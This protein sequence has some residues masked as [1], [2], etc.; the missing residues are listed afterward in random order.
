MQDEV[1]DKVRH[2]RE[3]IQLRRLTTVI[4]VIYA[5]VIWRIF[6]LLPAPTAEQLTWE[7][8]GPFLVANIF[9][10]LIVF[11]GLVV[12]IIYWL[13]HNLL[14]G[15]LQSTDTRHSILSILQIF[16]LLAFLLSLREGIELGPSTGTRALESVTAA[17]VGIAGG[18]GWAYAIKNHRLLL[19]EVTEQYALQLRDRILAEPITAVIT[20]PCA[21]VGPIIWEIS[22]LSYPLVVWLVRRSRRDKN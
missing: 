7:H 9:V 13:Q 3:T 11:I 21:F 16:F 18:W 2:K 14:F 4:D 19:P 17:L 20:I 5:I 22:W 6:I 1:Q 10:F 8:I 15:N 12:T